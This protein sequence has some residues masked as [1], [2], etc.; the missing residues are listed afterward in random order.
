MVLSRVEFITLL[1]VLATLG[2]SFAWGGFKGAVIWFIGWIV[3]IVQAS[4]I[5]YKNG[6]LLNRQK[7]NGDE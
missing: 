5:T 4:V 3:G 1:I 7:Q 2:A 6:P